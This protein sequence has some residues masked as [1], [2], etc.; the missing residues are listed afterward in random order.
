M[1]SA[2]HTQPSDAWLQ[3]TARVIADRFRAFWDQ[4]GSQL[5]LASHGSLVDYHPVDAE[6][7]AQLGEPRGEERLLHRHE[8]FS[9]IRERRKDAFCFGVAL[10]AQGQVAAPHRLGVGDVRAH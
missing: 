4:S 10:D 6:S 1:Y 8:H 5:W 3:R 2:L 7:I 9:S